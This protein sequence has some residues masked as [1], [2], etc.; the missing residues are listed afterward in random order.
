MREPA[1]GAAG[2]YTGKAAI[3]C[4]CLFLCGNT[5]YYVERRRLIDRKNQK[6]GKDESA[7]G[8]P[9]VCA[10]SPVCVYHLYDSNTS[11]SERGAGVRI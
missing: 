10:G 3:L 7:A 1:W 11:D 9:A 6:N 5:E 8:E 4:G 2:H